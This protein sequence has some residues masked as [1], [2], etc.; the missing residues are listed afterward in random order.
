LVLAAA[1]RLAADD[2]QVRAL[3]VRSDPVRVLPIVGEAGAAA[4]AEL[5]SVLE[6]QSKARAARARAA[7]EAWRDKTKDGRAEFQEIIGHPSQ[8]AAANARNADLVVVARPR[9]DNEPMAASLVEA[10]LFE[11]GRPVLVVPPGAA[12]KFGKH[13]VIFWDGS[14]IAARAL[15]DSLPLLAQARSALVLSAGSLDPEVPTGDVV[16]ARLMARGL[17][18]KARSLAPVEREAS[19]L[20]AAAQEAGCDLVVMGAYGHSRVREMILG[21]VTRHM[22]ASATMPL[23]MA[24]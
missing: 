3:A 22:L 17:A 15:G 4:A 6:E 24:H 12:T 19:A 14:R 5:M 21:G 18:A 11:S 2:G 13:I 1:A 10:C 8:T 23:L 20:A 16:A 7:F 9:N